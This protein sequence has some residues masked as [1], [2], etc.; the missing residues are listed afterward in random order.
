MREH[1]FNG[2]IRVNTSRYLM[3]FVLMVAFSGTAHAQGGRSSNSRGQ[4]Q[5]PRYAPQSPTVSPYLNLLSRTGSTA[6]NY[7]GLVRPLQRQQRINERTTLDATEQ[8]QQLQRLEAQQKAS[9]DQ[10]TVKPTG[11][12]G[13]FH[14]Y[15]TKSPYLQ[16]DHFYS[17]WDNNSGT[18]QR[19]TRRR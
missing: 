18:N 11:T 4:S 19:R 3:L 7:Y 13:W 2:G 6:G 16:T 17:Q 15:G 14:D 8:Q 1:L 9:F 10:P 5:V 12:A